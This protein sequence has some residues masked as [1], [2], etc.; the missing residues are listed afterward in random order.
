PGQVD[1]LV[2]LPVIA[3]LIMSP[4]DNDVYCTDG[5]EINI[6]EMPDIGEAVV[7]DGQLIQYQVFEEFA[8]RRETVMKYEIC[9]NGECDFSFIYI[10]VDQ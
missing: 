1:T 4:A 6:L 10:T 7:I 8:G 9:D 3:P 5:F 2:N